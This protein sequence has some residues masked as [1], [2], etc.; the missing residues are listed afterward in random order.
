VGRVYVEAFADTLD[1]CR[2][3]GL[4]YLEPAPSQAQMVARHAS[5]E[6]AAHPYFEKGEEIA[7]RNILPLHEIALG[8]LSKHLPI[9]SRV[10]DVGAGTGDFIEIAAEHYTV[11]AIE[12][13]PLLAEKIRNRMAC[14]VFV[15]AFEDYHQPESADAVILMDIIEHAAD[16]RKLLAQVRR[17]LRP[18]GLVFISTVDSASLL[19]RLGPIIWKVSKYSRFADYLLHRIFCKQHNWY[20]NRRVLGDIVKAT[21]FTVLDHQGFEFPLSRLKEKALVLLGLRTL[22]FFHFLLGSNTEQYLVAQNGHV[23]DR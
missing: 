17:T 18:G 16:P 8:I 14:P 7:K 21:G 20:F 19:Y 10:L 13:S 6:Y 3:C 1:K 5:E 23:T 15:G 2:S 9:G 12:P 4:I 11:S 22:Y